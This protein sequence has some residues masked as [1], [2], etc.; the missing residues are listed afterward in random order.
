MTS[1]DVIEKLGLEPLEHEGGFFSRVFS[2]ETEVSFAGTN[3]PAAT[4]IYFLVTPEDFS[5]LHILRLPEFYSHIAGDALG[6]TILD[7][8]DRSAK[9]VRLGPISDWQSQPYYLVPENVWQGLR[10]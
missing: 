9:T 7:P 3:R 1:Q 8:A 4:I 10:L 6:L 2:S 5:A